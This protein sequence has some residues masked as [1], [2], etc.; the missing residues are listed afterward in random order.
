MSICAE[1]VHQQSATVIAGRGAVYTYDGI[2]SHERTGYS[3]E[4]KRLRLDL[5]ACAYES[6]ACKDRAPL[7]SPG[8]YLWTLELNAHRHSHF[9]IIR[10]P[11]CLA[12]SGGTQGAELMNVW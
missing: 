2:G 4:V 5:S 11:W 3:C 1:G 6:T 7:T 12:G 9:I 10:M 8:P